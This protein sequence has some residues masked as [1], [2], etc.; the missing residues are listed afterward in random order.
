MARKREARGQANGTINSNGSN[1]NNGNSN[2]GLSPFFAVQVMSQPGF[3]EIS[4]AAEPKLIS[5]QALPSFIRLL[6]INASVFSHVWANRDGEHISSWRS[7][8]QEINR[9]RER[10]GPKTQ[11]TPSPPPGSLGGGGGVGS[12]FTGGGPL[13]PS[14]GAL[15]GGSVSGGVGGV[16]GGAGGVRE[17]FSSLRRSSVA[18]FFTN[19]STD[20]ASHRSSMP[21]T[22]T[23]TDGTEILAL[24]GAE[25][26]VDSVDFSKWT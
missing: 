23:T 12:M 7:R 2:S 22:A 18:T 13:Q 19:T 8:L 17:S 15:G 9:L 4:P 21:S 1:S 14:L 10:Y 6:A 5:L 25:A 24:N 16:T 11:P 20:M 26:L 3:P